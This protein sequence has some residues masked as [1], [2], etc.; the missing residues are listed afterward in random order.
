MEVMDEVVVVSVSTMTLPKSAALGWALLEAAVSTAVDSALNLGSDLAGEH[1]VLEIADSAPTR[2]SDII[3]DSTRDAA[4]CKM[5]AETEIQRV[6][7]LER[8]LIV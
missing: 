5:A 8:E 3:R 7:D 4:V 2:N 6:P 1:L